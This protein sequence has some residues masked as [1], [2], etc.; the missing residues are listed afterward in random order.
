MSSSPFVPALKINHLIQIRQCLPASRV[1]T[2]FSLNEESMVA[3]P[4]YFTY[5]YFT[6]NNSSSFSSPTP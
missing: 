3:A 2:L 6:N 4:Y 1:Q 5:P